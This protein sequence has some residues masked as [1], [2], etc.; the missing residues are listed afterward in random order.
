VALPPPGIFT[1]QNMEPVVTAIASPR[2][3]Q[4]K[5]GNS[6][7]RRKL[8]TTAYV[9]I[10]PF[11]IA[12]VAM[13]L[14]PIGYALY[15]SLFKTQIIGGQ[16][17]I[18]LANYFQAFTDPKLYEGL[19]RI[20]LYLV[21]QVPVM[22]IL[23]IFF[24]FAIDSGRVKGSKFVRL[25]IFVPY[26]IPGVIST[27]MWGYF[28]GNNFGLIA[29]LFRAV[30]VTPPDLLSSQNI[31]GSMMNI[32]TWQFVGYN[33]III[34]AALRSIPTELYDSAEVDGA[35]QWRIAW[36]I[37]LPAIRSAIF[38]CL[39]FSVIGSFQIFTEPSLLSALAPTVIDN[40]FTPTYY[41]YN[42]AFINQDPSYAAAIAFALGFTIM[43]VSY[44]VQLTAQRRAQRS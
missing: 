19:S 23:A 8:S 11:L 37:K 39:I 29:Q 25:A 36:S 15:L 30:G 40:Q 38:L 17:F 43:I 35:G 5:S 33:M 3:K 9:F 31:L 42:L 34:Y 28:Y 27:L 4:V 20:L 26:A 1:P 18:G 32:S 44:I 6:A 7:Q 12:F 41:A 13:L 16:T 10:A 2:S 24:A 14:V 21:I 22:L